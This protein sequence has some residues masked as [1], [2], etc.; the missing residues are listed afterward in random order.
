MV[1]ADLGRR[2]DLGEPCGRRLAL[3]QVAHRQRHRR[4]APGEHRGD[5]E[6]DPGVAAGDHRDAAALVG[7]V[8]IGPG[9]DLRNALER[10]ALE[11]VAERGPQGFTLAEACR[12]AGVSVAAPYKHFADR[13]ALLAALAL[14]SY[15]EQLRRYRAALATTVEPAEQLAAFAVAYVR[16]AGEERALFEIAFLAGLDKERHPELA[17]AGA[18]L[19]D[20]MMPVARRVVAD[21]DW[22][23]GLFTRVAAAAHGLALF[24]QQDM[25][26]AGL[27]SR[28][29]A[30][31][32]A[33]RTAHALVKD[34]S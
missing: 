27:N 18:E 31:Q 15:R 9:Q 11:L 16:F 32:Q 22:A 8:S 14:Q 28:E 24:V 26:P 30:E 23:F 12:R 2:R 13:E 21:P 33:A 10:A 19:Y 34:V 7:H 6:A 17:R 3:L 25:L 4:P 29:N 5:L 1:H 20:T